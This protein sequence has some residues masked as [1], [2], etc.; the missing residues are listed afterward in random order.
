MY[1]LSPPWQP[2]TL[3]PPGCLCG[4][5]G[6]VTAGDVWR[7]DRLADTQRILLPSLV[8]PERPLRGSLAGAPP[9][10]P[11]PPQQTKSWLKQPGL[12]VAIVIGNTG[13]P[14]SKTCFGIPVAVGFTASPTEFLHPHCLYCAS[15]YFCRRGSFF[16]CMMHLFSC[17]WICNH[18]GSWRSGKVGLIWAMPLQDC[19]CTLQQTTR[20]FCHLQTKDSRNYS[21]Q[22]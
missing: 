12:P 14:Q 22:M 13:S 9:P 19:Y 11:L 1:F 17:A 20:G 7:S 18:L 16:L 2:V 15:P 5:S 10:T 6:S 3:W 8:K 4:M 21:L